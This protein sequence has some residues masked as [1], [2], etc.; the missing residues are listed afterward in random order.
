MSDRGGV[1]D[2]AQGGGAGRDGGGA[3]GAG[4]AP[5]AVLDLDRR[6][7]AVYANLAVKVALVAAFVVAIG[8]APSTVDGKAMGAR[9]PLFLAPVVLV[10]LVTLVLPWGMAILPSGWGAALSPSESLESAADGLV[11]TPTPTPTPMDVSFDRKSAAETRAVGPV[12]GAVESGSAPVAGRSG[13]RILGIAWIAVGALILARIVLGMAWMW[14][15]AR[16]AEPLAGPAWL[17]PLGRVIQRL[18]GGV[19]GRHESGIK[20]IRGK[21]LGER[22]RVVGI[23][24]R[25]ARVVQGLDFFGSWDRLA[26]QREA[27]YE[28]LLEDLVG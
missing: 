14:R 8:L 13:W 24:V 25:Q 18:E 4:G 3:R 7:V 9:A 27:R 20:G 11:D 22:E 1:V 10:P 23:L 2:T 12:G 5:T 28:R 6:P 15:L 16:R 17:L 19:R 26:P 21:R